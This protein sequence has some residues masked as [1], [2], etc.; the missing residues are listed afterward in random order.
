MPPLLY[1]PP[2]LRH[3]T[4]GLDPPM[5][6]WPGARDNARRPKP[7]AT[8]KPR[9]R[10]GPSAIVTTE[11]GCG[12]SMPG[13]QD[14]TVGQRPVLGALTDGL[15]PGNVPQPPPA[16]PH[17]PPR[18]RR[19]G[20]TAAPGWPQTRHTGPRGNPQGATTQNRPSM[21][22][23]ALS[24][25]AGR[26][27]PRPWRLPWARRGLALGVGPC[28]PDTMP[29]KDRTRVQPCVW[30]AGYAGA[31]TGFCGLTMG[32]R[33]KTAHAALERAAARSRG[34]LND[35]TPRAE[36]GRSA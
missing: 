5:S 15:G 3:Y 27:V 35:P 2:D 8:R 28:N 23:D 26:A 20:T 19:P 32:R 34:G 9:P 14:A 11:T 22:P 18:G 30:G 33:G 24:G 31:A 21:A 1:D 17:A 25:G 29:L 6:A 10:K 12:P 4:A 36:K 7:K 16:V 13:A